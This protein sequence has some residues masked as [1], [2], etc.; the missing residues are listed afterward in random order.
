MLI[1]LKYKKNNFIFFMS[2]DIVNKLTLNLLINKEQMKKLSV[3]Q[4]IE[5]EDEL[6][7]EDND[8]KLKELFNNLLVQQPPKDISNKVQ[9]AFDVF[10]N[11]ALNYLNSCDIDK[12]D[13][14][15]DYDYDKEERDIEKGNY[16]IKE[17]KKTSWFYNVGHNYIPRMKDNSFN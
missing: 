17:E 4:N 3:M 11:E 1:S 6:T 8:D 2:E 15:D 12:V 5:V 7:E 14:D 13:F 16:S 10:V 9:Q